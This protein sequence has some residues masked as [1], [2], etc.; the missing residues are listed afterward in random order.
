MCPSPVSPASV[1][2][3]PSQRPE[4]H[5]LNLPLLHPDPVIPQVLPILAPGTCSNLPLLSIPSTPCSLTRSLNCLPWPCAFIPAP[6]SSPVYTLQLCLHLAPV[7]STHSRQ[8]HLS[9]TQVLPCY[10]P[11]SPLELI[12]RGAF[13]LVGK[14]NK[15]KKNTSEKVR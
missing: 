1:D 2:W 14:Q 10:F 5:P 9:K 12:F 7:L 13:D 15:T 4:S 3:Y 8:S 11:P 6:S